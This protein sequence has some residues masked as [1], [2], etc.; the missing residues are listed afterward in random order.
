MTLL[1]SIK[2]R[3]LFRVLAWLFVLIFI[4][5]F[6]VLNILSKYLENELEKDIASQIPMIV[7]TSEDLIWAYNIESLNQFY[8]AL[9]SNGFPAYIELNIYGDDAPIVSGD[10]SIKSESIRVKQVDIVKRNVE[11]GDIS[12]YYS[13]DDLNNEK[14]YVWVSSTI[15]ILATFVSGFFVFV[16][17]LS[18][19]ILTP[20]RKMTQDSS[21]LISLIQ[22]YQDSLQLSQ[23]RGELV[24]KLGLIYDDIST[25]VYE[26]EDLENIR[27]AG[28]ALV[29]SLKNTLLELD[30][31]I[32]N[33]SKINSELS[34]KLRTDKT[35]R[36]SESMKLDEVMTELKH[37]QSMLIQQEKMATVGQMA[38]GVA[39]EINNPTGYIKSNLNSM[40]KYIAML[41]KSLNG[42]DIELAEELKEIVTDCQE[43]IT[44]IQDIVDSLK[45]YSH[46]GHESD[47]GCF[48]VDS[49][50]NNAIK[51]THNEVKYFA[52]VITEIQSDQLIKGKEGHLTQVLSNLITNSVHAIHD[53]NKKEG[54]IRIRMEL[55][56][57]KIHIW[58]DDNGP[59]MSDE[60]KQKC[61]EPFYTTKD[62][63]KGTGLGL[64]I[65]HDMVTRKLNGE[66]AFL[67]S[68]LG[69][70]SVKLTFDHYAD[71]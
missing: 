11:I 8:K 46:P 70:L 64:H 15:G 17:I 48:S 60:Q 69:G 45:S 71:N 67:D 4:H 26:S 18:K 58:V 10:G 65:S 34:D 38:A 33:L 37:A 61:I 39:H 32:E 20:M 7:E 21:L 42:D 51:L 47:S 16:R 59:G 54:K 55:E 2:S 50:I 36:K 29:S 44:K 5:S 3:V 41:S 52:E 13:D 14:L 12:L 22:E 31:L 27:D 6:I 30:D 56:Q 43:G 9:T 35:K 40:S 62:V 25:D 63:G 57:D 24:E 49:A 19:E 28:K 1:R 68:K 53:S 66:M 23:S